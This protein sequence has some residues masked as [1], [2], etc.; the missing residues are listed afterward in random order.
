MNALPC[1]EVDG[2]RINSSLA[3]CRYIARE[4]GLA[5]SDDWENLQIDT[6]ADTVN[7]FRLSE[8]WNWR[9]NATEIEK[10]KKKLIGFF[11]IRQRLLR[12]RMS[13]R[14]MSHRRRWAHWH[15]KLFPSIWRSSKTLRET[16][17]DFWQMEKY[18]RETSL[19]FE[20]NF[21]SEF[22]SSPPPQSVVVGRLL[23]RRYHRLSQLLG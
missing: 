9:F 10:K 23:F 18:E 5:G 21:H 17:M 7:D 4:V 19:Q 1:L 6:I 2:K 22:S 3:C 15:R 14:T 12:S 13:Q 11:V 8:Q 16:I 20:W